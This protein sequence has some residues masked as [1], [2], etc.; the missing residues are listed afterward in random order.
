MGGNCIET[1]NSLIFKDSDDNTVAYVDNLG[2]LCIETGDCSD[3]SASCS[4]ESSLF[5]VKDTGDNTVIYIDN[6]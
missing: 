4:S 3:Q 2:N 6:D 1:D 5:T